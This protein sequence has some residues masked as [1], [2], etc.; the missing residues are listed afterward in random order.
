MHTY[1]P[2]RVGR[3]EGVRNAIG[4]DLRTST[5][6]VRMSGHTP[7]RSTLLGRR[8]LAATTSR[9]SAHMVRGAAPVVV[10]Q[11][12]AA[13]TSATAWCRHFRAKCRATAATPSLSSRGAARS[14]TKPASA[15]RAGCSDRG[16][17]VTAAIWCSVD[18]WTREL[19]S[20]ARCR[21]A[22]VRRANDAAINAARP[23]P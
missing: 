1:G 13:A 23:C 17:T 21:A 19:P 16:A 5:A 11:S 10:A 9:S 4:H 8:S 3:R 2:V 15:A 20:R 22:S 14:A 18:R 12:R 6:A 7:T